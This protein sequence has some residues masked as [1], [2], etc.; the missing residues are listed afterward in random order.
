MVSTRNLAS[1]CNLLCYCIEGY[2]DAIEPLISLYF[3]LFP[4]L[5][6]D[7]DLIFS[8][9]ILIRGGTFVLICFFVNQVASS[10]NRVVLFL[11]LT[12]PDS[13]IYN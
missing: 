10:S 7:G 12:S 13:L 1:A 8:N 11:H 2:F 6:I 4:L 5:D 3:T 9:I